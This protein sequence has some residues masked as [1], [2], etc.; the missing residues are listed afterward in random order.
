M[1]RKRTRHT[2]KAFEFLFQPLFQTYDIPM[3]SIELKDDEKK[4]RN[5]TTSHARVCM[6]VNVIVVHDDDDAPQTKYTNYA[7]RLGFFLYMWERSQG[8][9][10][11]EREIKNLLQNRT[12]NQKFIYIYIKV[13]IYIYLKSILIH[14]PPAH[15]DTPYI[16]VS[17]YLKPKSTP[18]H[19][20]Q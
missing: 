3:Y 20:L 12:N 19:T 1:F 16:H 7:K 10:D 11:R 8:A 5:S 18:G 17:R 15:T 14:T 2:K 6:C 4:N 13:K 9:R